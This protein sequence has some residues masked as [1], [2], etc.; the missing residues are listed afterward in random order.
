TCLLQRVTRPFVHHFAVVRDQRTLL[1]VVV[2]IE[3][4]RP[5]FRKRLNERRQVAREQQARVERHRGRQIQRG[6]NRYAVCLDG[7]TRLRQLAVA[8]AVGGEID[9]D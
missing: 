6:E 5:V 3:R 7:L 4:E 2:E 1:N 9:D 8:A